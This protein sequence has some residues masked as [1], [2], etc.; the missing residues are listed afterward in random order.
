[1][2]TINDVTILRHA[3]QLCEQDGVA[4]DSLCVTAPG[5]RVL[6]DQGRRECLMRARDELM[7]AV[8]EAG[9][10]ENPMPGVEHVAAS[11]S[12]AADKPEELALPPDAVFT[13]VPTRRVA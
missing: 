1:M 10:L 8:E 13:T 4:W 9:V 5:M 12:Q 11:Q 3:R 7:R 6:T 2:L